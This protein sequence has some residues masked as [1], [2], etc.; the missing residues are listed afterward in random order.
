MPML[1]KAGASASIRHTNITGMIIF[2]KSRDVILWDD[3]MQCMATTATDKT[4]SSTP[5]RMLCSDCPRIIPTRPSPSP[6]HQSRESSADASLLTA[7]VLVAI[8]SN[9]FPTWPVL[10]LTGSA[11]GSFVVT[12]LY[13]SSSQTTTKPSQTEGASASDSSLGADASEGQLLS[14]CLDPLERRRNCRETSSSILRTSFHTLRASS[15]CS[16]SKDRWESSMS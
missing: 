11:A 9:L 4:P 13:L 8:L 7:S 12:E 2:L 14:V 6:R 5:S 10:A 1:M 3:K 15:G 16:N